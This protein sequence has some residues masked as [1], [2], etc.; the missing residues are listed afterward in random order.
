MWLENPK[1]GIAGFALCDF[2]FL[3]VQALLTAGWHFTSSMIHALYFVAIHLI[4]HVPLWT[5]IK[6]KIRS[7][8]SVKEQKLVL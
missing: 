1:L 8:E 2:K 3:S 6:V 7:M 5:V 4:T